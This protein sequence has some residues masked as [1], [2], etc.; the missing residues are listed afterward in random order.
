MS[1]AG[2][3]YGSGRTNIDIKTG[4]RFGVISQNSVMPEAI[5]DFEQDYGDPHCPK[6]GNEVNRT[7]AIEGADEWEYYSHGSSDYVCEECKHWLDSEDVFSD[8]A[9]GFNYEQDGYTLTNCLDN[10]IF[11]I[12]SPF[13]T[14]AQ[15]CS[16]CVPGAGNLDT[17]ILNGVKTY[18]LSHD[19][20]EG[21]EAPYLVF[22]VDTNEVVN[23]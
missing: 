5:N 12:A 4:I 22:R 13:Y 17:P 3:D 19:W 7:T 20:F 15:Y 14:F 9:I 6:C 16:P 10:D 8:E 18:C 1:N 23:K 2:I 11:V 21:G